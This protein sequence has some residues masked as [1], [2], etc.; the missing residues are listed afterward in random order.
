MFR[1]HYLTVYIF[2]RILVKRGDASRISDPKVDS[3][4]L[5]TKSNSCPRDV[6]VDI[7]IKLVILAAK[8]VVLLLAK[9]QPRI[10]KPNLS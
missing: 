3:I 8:I 5:S 2:V 9:S 6:P 1:A 10:E 4:R 7:S